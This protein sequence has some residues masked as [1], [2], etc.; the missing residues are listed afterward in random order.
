MRELIGKEGMHD[1]RGI[2]AAQLRNGS[3]FSFPLL[4]LNQMLR[5]SFI[6]GQGAIG[7]VVTLVLPKH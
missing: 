7:V 2:R 6:K 3:D 1:A 5:D 4:E